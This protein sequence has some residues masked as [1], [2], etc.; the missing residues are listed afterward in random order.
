[1]K[2][3]AP[4]GNK[5]ERQAFDEVSSHYDI[6]KADLDV[7]ITDFD[8]KDEL[9]RSYIDESKWPY[10]SIVFDPR[11]F[12]T[13]F[14]K[15]SRLLANKPRGRMVPR[16]GGDSLG[17]KINNEL[18]SFQWD[19]NERV[20]SNPMLAKW[21]MMDMNARKYGASFALCTWHWQRMVKRT[22]KEGE[23]PNGKSEIF[24]DG[25]NF[26]PWDNRDVLVNPS[27]SSI[28]NWIQL[29][30]YPT[31]QELKDTND[32]ARSKPIYKNL[33]ILHDQ[34]REETDSSGGGDK[35]SSNYS[36]KNKDI[37]GLIDYLGEDEVFKTVEVVTE[38]RNDRWITF[39]PRYGVVIRDIPNP[40]DHGQIPVVMLKY[41]AIDDDIYGLSEIEPV[42]KLQRATNAL[43]CQYLD[44]INMSLYTPIKVRS[45][46]G[47]V[48]MHTLEFGPG[49]KW[50]MQDPSADVVPFDQQLTGVN[51]FTATYRFMISAMMEGLGE[52]SQG[53]SNLSPGG[54]KKTATEVR[55]MA[56]SRSARDNFN[57]I[58]LSEAIKKQ[59]M[60]WHKMNQQLL[61]N[62]NEQHKVI[63]IVGKEAI[64]Y[65]QKLGLDTDVL[66]DES[67]EMLKDPALSGTV[68]PDD[69]MSPMYPIQTPDGIANKLMMEEDGQYGSLIIEPDDLTG[70]YDFVADVESMHLPDNNQLIAAGKQ[71][72]ELALNPTT[73][74]MLMASGYQLEVKELLE[75]YFE[76]L[77]TKDAD[78]YF[79]KIQTMEGG[80]N[81]QAIG[82]DGQPIPGGAGGIPPG[83][84]G[85]VNVP[86]A[87]MAPSGAPVPNRQAQP[88]VS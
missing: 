81:G 39:A 51:E 80:L 58:F 48:Q 46:G 62:K 1:M 22:S 63:R 65:F 13:I 36:S 7:R 59:M 45:T 69:L 40:Y 55:D 20:D 56:I 5:Q 30:S 47:A 66:T 9:F 4:V 64:A 3:I 19:D 88:I 33:D 11:I 85:G 17:A 83:G 28:K 84:L 78:K 10:R 41:Y 32:A 23:K 50:L 8:K 72:V 27:Y 38:Y 43:I 35:R 53:I 60:F 31:F 6:S 87:G 37:S 73:T 71:M 12:T 16:E 49:A 18:L 29:R 44:A 15:T 42:E 77:G 75:D 52:T 34:I 86:G 70:N 2:D 26:K 24:Y 14:E 76:K 21:A 54:D 74:Q 68:R 57:S 67:E 61:F 82:P 79:K 25:P